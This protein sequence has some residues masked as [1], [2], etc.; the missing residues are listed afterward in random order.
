VKA[1]FIDESKAKDF[2]LCAVEVEVSEI[3]RLRRALH[4]LTLPGQS[5][6][7]FVSESSR[8]RRLL[9]NNYKGLPLTISILRVKGSIGVLSRNKAL[10][11]LTSRLD[12]AISYQL[13]IER[14]ENHINSDQSSLTRSLRRLG[15]ENSVTFFHSDSKSQPLLWLPDAFAWLANRGG[16][17]AK[18]LKKFDATTI[19]LD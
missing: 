7:H 2:I 19:Y 15:M 9:V 18:E 12:S 17:W 3:P 11:A 1:I 6:I 16:D 10:E 13:W 4:K 14:D 5:R 8:R